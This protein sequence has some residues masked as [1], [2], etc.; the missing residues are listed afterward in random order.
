MDRT[1]RAGG[2]LLNLNY[3][4]RYLPLPGFIFGQEI[5]KSKTLPSIDAVQP[6]E[7]PEATVQLSQR[8]IHELINS[9]WKRGS[10]RAFNC[11]VPNG[12]TGNPVRMDRN[13]S[14]LA[15]FNTQPAGGGAVNIGFGQKPDAQ[16]GMLPMAPG[17]FVLFDIFVPI[18]DIFIFN[19]SGAVVNMYVM[20]STL[21]T[22]AQA[23]A[24]MQSQYD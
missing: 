5:A 8:Q 12:V 3:G 2:G 14:F 24:T 17:G 15:I 21:N 11:P 16:N 4:R 7:A 10:V 18:D 23:K 9:G 6:T 20:F 1:N 19:G 22:R 13:R